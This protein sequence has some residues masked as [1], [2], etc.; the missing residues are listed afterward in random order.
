MTQT[1]GQSQAGDVGGLKG[2]SL[3]QA[4]EFIWRKKDNEQRMA[5][6]GHEMCV[7][8]FQHIPVRRSSKVAMDTAALQEAQLCLQSCSMEQWAVLQHMDQLGERE[9][10]GLCWT[11]PRACG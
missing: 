6:Q 11:D 4:L 5:V 7:C 3:Q 1:P 10:P 8:M 9:L 2:R